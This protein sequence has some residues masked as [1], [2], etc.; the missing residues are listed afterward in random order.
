V[1]VPLARRV[2]LEVAIEQDIDLL[3]EKFKVLARGVELMGSA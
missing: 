1:G 2:E 3:A